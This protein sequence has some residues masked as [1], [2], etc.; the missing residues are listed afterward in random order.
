MRCKNGYYNLLGETEEPLCLDGEFLNGANL[1]RW[2][3][4][5]TFRNS[6]GEFSELITFRIDI[7]ARPRLEGQIYEVSAFI[8]R[9]K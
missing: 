2:E 1:S 8:T 4:A 6:R 3:S 7:C 9:W 5:K